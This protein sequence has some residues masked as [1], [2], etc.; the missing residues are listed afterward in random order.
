[1]RLCHFGHVGQHHRHAVGPAGGPALRHQ[2]RC[3][4][5]GCR[6]AG[7]LAALSHAPLTQCRAGL[8]AIVARAHQQDGQ[9]FPSACSQVSSILCRP[10]HANDLCKTCLM[11]DVAASFIIT[12]SISNCRQ[13]AVLPQ[14]HHLSMASLTASGTAHRSGIAWPQLCSH[15]TAHAS[16]CIR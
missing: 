2:Q 14:S 3:R 15:A 8:G 5:G 6:P 13:I 12:A 10:Y 4:A 1:M 7:L 16:H 9:P 11:E